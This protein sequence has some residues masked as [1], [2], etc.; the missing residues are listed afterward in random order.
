MLVG[1]QLF[2]WERRKLIPRNPANKPL[3]GEKYCLYYHLAQ[4]FPKE[5]FILLRFDVAVTLFFFKKSEKLCV[6]GS[7]ACTSEL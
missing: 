5:S 4:E 2:T 3:V 6:Y 1:N 7:C